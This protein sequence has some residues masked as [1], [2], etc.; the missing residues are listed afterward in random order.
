MAVHTVV[1][2]E[3]PTNK[4]WAVKYVSLHFLGSLVLAPSSYYPGT[5]AAA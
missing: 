2:K 4:K 1:I 3:L 5:A